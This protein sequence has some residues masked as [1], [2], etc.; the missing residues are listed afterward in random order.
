V[1]TTDRLTVI[2]IGATVVLVIIGGSC[3]TNARIDDL[4]ADM[5]AR[6]GDVNARFADVS[7][8]IGDVNAR[9]DDLNAEVRAEHAEIRT[10]IRRID[11]RLRV[12]ERAVG[13]E[14]P[15]Q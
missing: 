15:A 8:R 5:N 4:R 9:I 13:S 3:S 7:A 1:T 11:D 10:D 12:V 14:Q 2:G 6:F